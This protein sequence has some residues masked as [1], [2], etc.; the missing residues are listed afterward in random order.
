METHV[1]ALTPELYALIFA[2][3][4]TL[5]SF[6]IKSYLLF[7]AIFVSMF[8]IVVTDTFANTWLSVS[9]TLMMV[10]ALAGVIRLRTKGAI[11]E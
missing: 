1:I 5:V 4:L 8:G 3:A 2:L 11:D 6:W 7:A 10:W 9:A